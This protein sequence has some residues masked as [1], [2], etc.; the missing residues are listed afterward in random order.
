V[1]PCSLVRISFL[2]NGRGVHR[3]GEISCNLVGGYGAVREQGCRERVRARHKGKRKETNRKAY[4]ARWPL[5][6]NVVNKTNNYHIAYWYD[7]SE[8]DKN[9]YNN[10]GTPG[11][12]PDFRASVSCA[13]FFLSLDG[14]VR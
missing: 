14:T 10:F 3:P 11:P 7:T 13:D 6:A 4:Y 8:K 1:T 12:V 9:I 5:A 2:V